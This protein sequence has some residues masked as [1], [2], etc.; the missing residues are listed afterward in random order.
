MPVMAAI[1]GRQL[2]DTLHERIGEPGWPPT[3]RAQRPDGVWGRVI[4]LDGR[5]DGE[6]EGDTVDP[7]FDFS[8]AALQLGLDLHR[9][10]TDTG[11]HDRAGLYAAFGH[12]DAS[13]EHLAP[14]RRID[15][16]DGSFD[17]WSLGGYW[18]RT[19]RAGWYLDGVLQATWYDMTMSAGRGL[20]PGETDGRG[21]GAS[22]E[23]GYPVA[24][25]QGWAVE[26]QAQLVYQDLAIDG[27]DDGAAEV[28][29]RDLDSLAGRVGARLAR[30]WDAGS[31]P[32][33]AWGRIDLWHEFL[34]NPVTEFSA[35]SGPV[36]F[37]AELD[38]DW[39]EI[40]LGAD[41]ALGPAS[42]LYGNASYQATFDGDA[43]AWD[44]EI[45]LKFRW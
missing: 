36:P 6:P 29:Y 8:L 24:L 25:G 38:E 41:L 14:G 18:T 3:D 1:Y 17:A 16:G 26:P 30:A 28:S 19:G 21:L 11:A 31:G 5:H 7:S 2:I 35:Q 44:A 43:D 40:G 23:A 12:A 27:F 32:M 15:A 22:L 13:V 39:A 34:G 9:G 20:R 42:F 33:A 37:T 45:G 10:E 4:G